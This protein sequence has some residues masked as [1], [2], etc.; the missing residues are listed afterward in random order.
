[1]SYGWNWNWIQ[2]YSDTKHSSTAVAKGTMVP[3]SFKQ[4]QRG[5]T[6]AS[7]LNAAFA[8]ITQNIDKFWKVI[9]NSQLGGYVG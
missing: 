3:Y 7:E 9:A 5:Q 6:N 2:S 8:G 4:T 1:M